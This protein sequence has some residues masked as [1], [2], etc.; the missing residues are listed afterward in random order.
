MR[1]AADAIASQQAT[2]RAL[3]DR[4]AE[5]A[6]RQIDEINPETARWSDVAKFAFEAAMAGDILDELTESENG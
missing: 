3:I 6:D 5:I 1:T 4:F 2:F